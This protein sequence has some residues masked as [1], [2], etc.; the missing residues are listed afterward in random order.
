MQV[1]QVAV[2][3]MVPLVTTDSQEDQ[4]SLEQRVLLVKVDSLEAWGP[5]AS[6]DQRANLAFQD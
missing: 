3:A 4:V 5:L 1:T 6:Q 2:V